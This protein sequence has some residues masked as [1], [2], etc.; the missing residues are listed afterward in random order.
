M[1]SFMVSKDIACVFYLFATVVGH[2]G[3]LGRAFLDDP[4]HVLLVFV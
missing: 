3:F 4:F 2:W 1:T